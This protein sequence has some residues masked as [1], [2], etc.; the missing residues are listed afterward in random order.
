MLEVVADHGM[1]LATGHLSR[2]EIFAVVD[3]AV[4][5]RRAR[6]RHHAPRLPVPV[7]LSID[8]QIALARKG[9]LLERCF[10]TFHTE[11]APWERMLEGIRA[12]GVENNVLSTDLGQRTNPPVEDGLPLMA[13]R[14]LEA[15][16]TEDEVR[17]VTVTNTRRMAGLE[18]LA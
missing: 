5:A 14:M 10:V 18:V 17:T 9:A 15:G 13:D 1:L 6:H 12:T 16:F 8:D 3:A 2:D 11:K 7:A 4:R